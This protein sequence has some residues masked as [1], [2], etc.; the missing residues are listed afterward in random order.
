MATSSSRLRAGCLGFTMFIA[1]SGL[2]RSSAWCPAWVLPSPRRRAFTAALGKGPFAPGARSGRASCAA[3]Y[4]VP[5]SVIC[6][7]T[8]LRTIG[9]SPLRCTKFLPQNVQTGLKDVILQRF[10][11]GEKDLD[12]EH[13]RSRGGK[14]R[15]VALSGAVHLSL[16][17][18]GCLAMV[19]AIGARRVPARRHVPLGDVGVA[20]E[21]LVCAMPGV[22]RPRYWRK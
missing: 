17:L 12:G 8:A 6:W 22:R 4:F 1:V 19:D 13:P 16:P 9:Q 14:C 3:A 18:R 15:D 7:A 21:L 5:R 20:V 11:I 2:W 10:G